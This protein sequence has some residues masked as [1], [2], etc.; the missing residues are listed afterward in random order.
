MLQVQGQ[1][2]RSLAMQL[3]AL[4]PGLDWPF[5][6]QNTSYETQAFAGM[7]SMTME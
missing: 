3:T 7:M 2:G 1:A 6:A 4:Q 5:A